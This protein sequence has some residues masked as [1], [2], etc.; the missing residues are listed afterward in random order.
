MA[1]RGSWDSIQR[2]GLLST[3]ALLDLFEVTGRTR[4][5]IEAKHRPKNELIVHPS[6][7]QA[8]VRDQKPMDDQSLLC[9]LLDDIKPKDW[10]RLLNERVFMWMSRD[11]LRRMLTARSYCTLEHDVLEI[12]AAPL[13][14]AY[15][16]HI[17]LSPINSGATKP[18]PRKQPKRGRSTFSRIEDY[19]YAMWHDKG[20]KAGECVVE[21]AVTRGIPDIGRFVVRVLRMRGERILATI[22]IPV[23]CGLSELDPASRLSCN[24]QLGFPFT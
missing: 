2:Y 16:D 11:R 3:S 24:R 23:P 7:G 21:L 17:T 12:N 18:F 1:E 15:R 9:C 19:P 22:Y 6:R 13:V 8:V 14:A 20:K 4:E 10:Y 5:R